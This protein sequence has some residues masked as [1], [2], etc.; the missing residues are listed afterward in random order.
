MEGLRLVDTLIVESRKNAIP[1]LKLNSIVE[2]ARSQTAG[3]T[4]SQAKKTLPRL[5]IVRTKDGVF[6]I[7]EPR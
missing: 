1:I 2:L 4:F 5:R 3:L 7:S 6:P